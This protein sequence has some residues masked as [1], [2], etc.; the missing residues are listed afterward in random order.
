MHWAFYN[1]IIGEGDE[2]YIWI[3]DRLPFVVFITKISKKISNLFTV[4][5]AS[6]YNGSNGPVNWI[7]DFNFVI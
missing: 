2:N 4:I 5:K 3:F 1:T 7:N 6:V